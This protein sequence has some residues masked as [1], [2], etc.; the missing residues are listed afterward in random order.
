MTLVAGVSFSQ[1]QELT[2]DS[3]SKSRLRGYHQ[4]C[5]NLHWYCQE[6]TLNTGNEI[7]KFA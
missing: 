2:R 4:F 5:D 1:E 7:R 6:R 3:P